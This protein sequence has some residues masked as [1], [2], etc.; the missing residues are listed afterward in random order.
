MKRGVRGVCA[1]LLIVA[2]ALTHAGCARRPSPE[3][4][5]S[6][7][8]AA[9]A[10]LV[11]AFGE[12]GKEFER[13]TGQ[14]VTFS[15]GSTGQLA[16]QIAEGAPFDLFAAA[17]ISFVDD[18][19]R[20]GACDPA[21]KSLYAR[22]RVAVWTRNG[23]PRVQRIEDLAEPRFS[24]I[25]IANPEH[26]PYGRAAKEALQRTGTWEK[27]SGRIVYGENVQQTLKF[28]QSGN[29]D[30]TIVALSLASVATD[31]EL[32]LIDQAFH[33]PIDQALVVCKNGHSAARAATFVSFVGSAAGRAIMR[34]YGF[35]PPGE[36]ALSIP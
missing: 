15:F 22:G 3:A 2:I 31:G 32:L 5:A 25:A 33:R 12:V 1:S 27:V 23:I 30:A 35:I 26:A 7:K 13:R 10:D 6:F 9:A 16:K 36:T 28:A 21:T 11:F 29:A 4:A 24:K 34:R 17:N 19:V 18:V 14:P 20:A 8:V